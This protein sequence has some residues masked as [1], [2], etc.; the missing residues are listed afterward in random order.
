MID[1][2]SKPVTFISCFLVCLFFLTNVCLWS[3]LMFYFYIKRVPVSFFWMN[4]TLLCLC[5]GHAYLKVSKSANYTGSFFLLTFMLLE[6]T[7]CSESR[8]F[9]TSF[10]RGTV[11]HTFR[12]FT[13]GFYHKFNFFL[14]FAPQVTVSYTTSH[15][16]VGGPKC[17]TFPLTLPRYI[18]SSSVISL[19]FRRRVLAKKRRHLV[20]AFKNQRERSMRDFV[21]E[22]FRLFSVIKTKLT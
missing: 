16:R 11:H 8:F 7:C 6:N 5:N 18:T 3:V 10:F 20:S 12:T 22:I 13:A 19:R 9:S 14:S 15:Q 17:R 2:N 1:W 4:R 21:L